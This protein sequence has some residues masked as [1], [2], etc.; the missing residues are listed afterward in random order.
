MI[1]DFRAHNFVLV[2]LYPARTGQ[3]RQDTQNRTARTGQAEQNRLNRTGR[4]GKAEHD[5]QNK[6]GSTGQ[7]EQDRQNRTGRT[8]QKEQD[9]QN[10]TER[11]ADA[12]EDASEMVRIVNDALSCAENFDFLG[13]YSS[14]K[15]VKRDP[16]N[17]IYGDYFTMPIKVD[18]PDRSTRINFE[19]VMRRHC[20]LRV[21]MSLPPPIRKFQALF[22][23]AMRER[24]AGRVVM[25][26][27]DVSSMS[28]VAFHKKDGDRQWERCPEYIPIPSGIM[29]PGF[30][31]PKSV[32]LTG[33]A[34]SM[35]SCSGG[36]IAAAGG[37]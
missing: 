3:P 34:D 14:K 28:L 35:P 7:A 19:R 22:L 8:G 13:E 2:R 26:R 21:S 36:S 33:S 32:T 24:Y 16:S 5:R 17:P 23:K 4:T 12:G 11:A 10:R 27:P 20:G 18:F 30:S 9:R 6:T 31:L 1:I 37:G 25:A 29:L 15:V